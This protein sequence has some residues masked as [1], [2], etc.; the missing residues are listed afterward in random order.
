[1]QKS[2]IKDEMTDEAREE[3][4]EQAK[5][6][7]F[8]AHLFRSISSEIGQLFAKRAELYESAPSE[9]RIGLPA[10]DVPGLFAPL[11]SMAICVHPEKSASFV[12]QVLLSVATALEKLASERW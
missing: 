12:N 4:E 7:P 10:G 11:V 1:M 2:A 8:S 9:S 6:L 5:S 3:D